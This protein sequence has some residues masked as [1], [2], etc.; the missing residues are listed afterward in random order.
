[1]KLDERAEQEREAMPTATLRDVAKLAGV[2]L[3]TASQA[4]NGRP[5]VLPATRERVLDAAA[6]LGYPIKTAKLDETNGRS[7]E[8][9]VIGMLTK[10]DFDLPVEPN[11]FFSHVQLGIESECRAHN[12]SLMYAN[13]EMDRSNHPLSWPRMVSDQHV[14]GL[15]LIGT[16]I[17][18]LVGGL[19]RKLNKPIVLIDSYAPSFS[20]D[21]VLIDNVGGAMQAV[22]HLLD[23]GHRRIGL[24]GWN[25]ASP[26]DIFERREGYLRAL[27]A[28]GIG[29]TYIEEGPMHRNDGYLAAQR[30]LKRAP[31]VTAVFVTND[32]TAIGVLHAA[33]D[34]GLHV[35]RDLSIVGFDDI[36]L[37]REVNPPLTTILVHKTWL[38]KF[39]VQRL[40]ERA[41]RP[42]Q[43]QLTIT[44]ATQLIE[45]ESAAPPRAPR[46]AH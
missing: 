3:G 12:I 18:E 39:G 33:Q 20:F 22:T 34:M 8:L 45:R 23:L 7:T 24:I 11:V 35:P 14:D 16:Y 29:E 30:L 5:H 6:T 2:S 25:P 36:D 43:P 32:D 9:S 19:K 27:R 44:V 28:R 1:M 31:Q 4:L 40:I 13:I 46:A 42:D 38:G 17:E 26:P 37:A 41:H 15:L 21:S 10:H